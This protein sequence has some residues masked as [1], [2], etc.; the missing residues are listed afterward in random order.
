MKKFTAIV[1]FCFA[2]IM[3]AA[4]NKTQQKTENESE[5]YIRSQKASYE[6]QI[7]YSVFVP[8]MYEGRFT[9][10]YSLAE[11]ISGPD[12]KGYYVAEFTNGPKQ[13]ETIKTQDIILK[14]RKAE[15]SDLRKGMAVLVNHWDPKKQDSNARVDMWRKGVVYNLEEIGDNLVMLEF[16][17]D[18]NDFMATKE[19]YSLQNIRL[20]VE[21][22]IKDPRNF[23]D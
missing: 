4:C 18:R 21:P 23:L 13:G 11:K 14:T 1:M 7:M 15:A 3:L 10:Y 19:T 6:R 5:P 2:V 22:S 20:I 12:A 8:F 9:A 16:P 17:A